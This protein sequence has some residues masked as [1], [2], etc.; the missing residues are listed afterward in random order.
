MASENTLLTLRGISKSFPGV[1]ALDGVDF[2]LQRGEIH[3]LLG[4]NGAGKSTLIKVLTGVYPRD[5]GAIHLDGRPIDARSPHHAQSL[6]ISTV[7][8]EVNLV[9]ELSVAEN[10][11]LGLQG[12]RVPRWLPYL[13]VGLPALLGA[14]LG[15]WLLFTSASVPRDPGAFKYVLVWSLLIL[16]SAAGGAAVLAAAGGLTLHFW[17][18]LVK[19]WRLLSG[20]RRTSRRR[21]VQAM[22]RLEMNLDV[23][24]PL[25]SY[26][27]AIQQMVAIARALDVQAKVLILDEPTS[28]LDKD[29]V[30]QL[31]AMMR[32]LAAQGLGILFVT[33]FLEQ[34]Y[35]VSNRITILRNGRLVGSFDTARLPRLQ[36]VGHMLG[37]DPAEVT[38]LHER[39]VA[40]AAGTAGRAEVLRASGAGRRG[41]IKPFDLA[42]HGG[43]IV[44]LAG[45]LGSGRTEIAQLFFGVDP[46][47]TGTLVINGTAARIRRPRQ[48]IAHGM[49]L[50]PEDRKR[51][52]II[53]D[54]SVR[55]NL[56]LALQARRG[57]FRPI[58]RR[59]QA[60]LADK[61]IRTL[62]IV[63]SDAEKPVKFLSGGN[64]QKVIL[65][66]WLVCDPKLLLLD[67]PTRGID[68]GAKF[69][70][71]RLM[72]ELCRQGMAVL[73][74]S[75]ELEEVAR[76]AQRVVVLRDR[77]KIAELTGD[78]ISLGNI[79]ATIAGSATAHS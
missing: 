16:L 42:I 56:I 30:A 52:A 39:A 68:I 34:V 3:A 11:C 78:Q 63:T 10:I 50:C 55:E 25:S 28:S 33:H 37:R 48:A 26:S 54:L 6:G 35:A 40:A 74:I 18:T 61:Y 4:E 24:R 79:M 17:S 8:Q 15:L 65:G 7:Y 5:A 64:Q 21:A 47:D 32:K 31:F 9:P 1:R 70:I 44:G 72:E 58:S 14:G 12:V 71:A 60:A 27:L 45:L 23:A 22:A 13:L 66:R 46:A 53:P 51:A 2:T 29:E 73:F 67:E 69:E 77:E 76:S 38:A 20:A 57:W 19:I 36:L 62:N 43:E 75:S 59:K 49:A 41:A